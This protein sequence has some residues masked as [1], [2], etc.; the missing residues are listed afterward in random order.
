MPETLQLTLLGTPELHWQEQVVP[1]QQAKLL[2]LLAFLALSPDP[3]SREE[4]A[5]LLWEP[6]KTHN[7]RQALYLLRN[8]PG[9]ATWLGPGE[10]VSLR[11][12]TDV[13]RIVELT[14]ARQWSEALALWETPHGL[15]KE[16]LSGLELSGVPA[17]DDW[18]ETERARL[19]ARY[20]STLRAHVLDLQQAGQGMDALQ[21][22]RRLAEQH[23]YDGNDQRLLIQL[24]AEVS[25]LEH[26]LAAFERHRELLRD[27]LQTLPE[28]ETLALVRQLEVRL[29]GPA[30]RARL[31]GPVPDDPTEPLFGRDDELARIRLLVVPGARLLLQGLGGIGKTALADRLSAEARQFGGTVL[32]LDLGQAEPDVVQDALAEVLGIQTQLK[33]DA[34]ARTGVLRQALQDKQL[35]LLVLDDA[36]NVYAL[37]RT[38]EVIPPDLPTLVTA[39]L[40]LPNLTRVEV[41]RLDRSASL[42]LLSYH[43]PRIL[44][45]DPHS[46]ALCALLGD[47]AYGVRLAGL[48]LHRS[49]QSSAGLLSHLQQ[50]PHRLGGQEGIEA[51]MSYSLDL[52][53]DE[54]YEAFFGLG[55]LFAPSGTPELLALALCRDPEATEAALYTLVESGLAS[56]EARPGREVAVFRLHDLAWSY[57][58]DRSLL[59]ATSAAD[60]VRR[61][62]EQW[63]M[64][65][66]ALEAE[67]PNLLGAAEYARQHGQQGRLIALI[68]GLVSHGFLTAR[69]NPPGLLGLL[70]AAAEAAEAS[71]DWNAAQALFG[72][73]GDVQQAFLADHVSASRAYRHARQL[74]GQAGLTEREV[75]YAT[76]LAWSLTL[77]LAPAGDVDR[78]IAEA[79]ATARTLGDPLLLVRTLESGG[80]VAAR[81][82]QF[83]QAREQLLEGYDLLHRLLQDGTQPRAAVQGKLRNLTHNLGQAERRLGNIERA[84]T[85]KHEALTL[86]EAQEEQ[87]GIAR[88]Q[89]DI[90]ELL[91]ELHRAEEALLHLHRA[92]ALCLTL[93]MHAE[94]IRVQELTARASSERYPGDNDARLTS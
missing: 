67:L 59:R 15:P 52:V 50:F 4:L 24:E 25:S 90:G 1:L 69:G 36:W 33:G 81:R 7:V 70:Q 31:L 49:G 60:R 80:F 40:R 22:A 53:S 66:D 61:Y 89:I 75:V 94:L 37:A 91:T 43:A 68:L 32:W 83:S 41:G 64:N 6:G 93:G 72:K 28:P 88:A 77:T 46:D 2:A 38:L 73:V 39:R 58:R 51:L 74:A 57:A 10:R 47:H 42:H 16:L 55:G 12:E 78:L 13:S 54:A 11:A 84:L 26:A 92:E 9:A 35:S 79:T 27:E 62:A 76:L 18:L 82:G 45:S 19:D 17:F 23:P 87:L 71:A 48:T 86:A 3:V 8:L 44:V 63:T 85:L 21:A 5:A 65:M 14:S 34:S 20:L 56:R 29:G 30:P